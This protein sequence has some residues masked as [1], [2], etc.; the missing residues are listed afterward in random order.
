MVTS[1][2]LV[3]LNQLVK[4]ARELQ[5]TGRK[6][7]FTNGCFDI[8]HPGHACYLQEARSLGDILIVALNSDQS[9]RQLKGPGRP[10]VGEN[11]R[12]FV[13]AALQSVDYIVIFETLRATPVIEAVK[14]D[15]YVK[16]GDY[17]LETLD[18][19]EW[20][21]LEACG[22]QIALLPAVEGFSTTK[23]LALGMHS[24]KHLL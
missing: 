17:T 18:S 9:V 15:I 20:A 2:K 21:A 1:H 8:L 16:G 5:R 7:A 3:E 6:V 13:L 11:E 10:V 14:P 23:L 24:I 22:A 4:V 12:A 19:E